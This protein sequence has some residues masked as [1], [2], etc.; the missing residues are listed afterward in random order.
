MFRAGEVKRTHIHMNVEGSKFET[1]VAFYR[2]LFDAAP[3]LQRPQY[4]KWLLDDPALNFVVE[5]LEV[6]GDRPGIHHVGIQVDEE[7][8]LDALR[9]TLAAAEAPLLEVGPT[10]CCY[11]DSN[12]N[13]TADPQGIRWET[14]LS[15]GEAESYGAK[16]NAELEHY[17]ASEHRD[18]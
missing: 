9:N 17:V 16:T 11:A 5:V 7:A 3:T 10:R 2:T 13:W 15:Y 12:K 18:G 14:F 6:T 1:S 8:E 4:A